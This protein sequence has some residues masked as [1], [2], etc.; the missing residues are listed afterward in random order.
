MAKQGELTSA[1]GG[2]PLFGSVVTIDEAVFGNGTVA[3][4]RMDRCQWGD[5]FVS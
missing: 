2:Q 1:S 4:V 3:S 5:V